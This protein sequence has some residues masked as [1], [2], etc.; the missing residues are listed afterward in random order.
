MPVVCAVVLGGGLGSLARYGLD[1]L[2]EHR[3]DSLFPWATFT[4][5][6][7]GCFLNGLLVAA[8]IDTLGVPS[9]AARG[10]IVGF[11][12]AYTTFSTF[13]AETYQL[14]DLRH[15]ASRSRTSRSA[16]R[17]A[18]PQSRSGRRSGACEL[19]NPVSDTGGE[20]RA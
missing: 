13:G 8:V 9:W 12:G 4:I 1:T 7:T 20:T 16:Q 17:S 10:L 11:L 3:V 2:I 5:N 18:S 6:M 14:T 15:W 19:C